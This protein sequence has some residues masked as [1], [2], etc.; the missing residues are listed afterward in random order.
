MFLL[1]F[2]CIRYSDA[3]LGGKEDPGII[4]PSFSEKSCNP[5]DCLV[6]VA[7]GRTALSPLW[8][9]K[10]WGGGEGGSLYPSQDGSRRT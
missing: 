2:L 1:S 8:S 3:S 5:K 6:L 10:L 7:G 4:L 9:R